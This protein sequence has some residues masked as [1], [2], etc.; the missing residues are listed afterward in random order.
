MILY[1]MRHGETALN[2]EER[3]QG[4]IDTRLNA[5]GIEE[6]RAAGRFVREQGLV[7]DKV[8]SSHLSRALDTAALVCGCDKSGIRIDDRILEMNYGP[9]DGAC[10]SEL[11]E[12]TARFLRDPVHAPL[13]EGFESLAHLEARTGSFL[14]DLASAAAQEEKQG[15]EERILAVTHGVAIRA[16]LRKLDHLDAE[17]VWKV[18]IDNCDLLRTRWENG[19]YSATALVYRREK[20]GNQKGQL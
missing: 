5:A 20:D 18:R 11:D 4:Q 7:F 14:E 9:A 6:A 3:L 12:K 2:R 13:P 19:R 16:M 1:L 17:E 8:Y 10:F 15:R